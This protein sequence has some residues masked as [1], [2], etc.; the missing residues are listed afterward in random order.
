MAR[1]YPTRQ[2]SVLT[3]CLSR[4]FC[5]AQPPSTQGAGIDLSA[6]INLKRR[7]LLRRG[8]GPDG[9]DLKNEPHGPSAGKMRRVA[10]KRGYLGGVL[11]RLRW[12]TGRDD[13][14]NGIR[15]DHEFQ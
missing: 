3:T 9:R 8:L 14:V 15:S 7:T 11:E 6:L 1:P 5:R 13:Q 4:F 12:P 10:R 2:T